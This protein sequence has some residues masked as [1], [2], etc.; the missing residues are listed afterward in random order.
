MTAVRPMRIAMM[1]E[2]DGPGGAEMMVLQL[3][4]ELRERGH[5]IVPVGPAKGCGW[6]ADLFRDAGMKPEVFHMKR[7]I[8]PGCVRGL[9][10]LFREHRIDAVHSHEF[11]MAVYGAASARLMGLPQV[12]T[13]HGGFTACKTRRRRIALRWA[14]KHSDHT[15]MVSRATQ[16]QFATDLG[17]K[18]SRMTVVPNGVPLRK[19]TAERVR[20]EFGVK[21][22]ECVMVAVGTLERHKG[23]HILLDALAGL[24]A[25]G[26]RNPWRLIIAGGR[27]GDQHEPLEEFI[28][29]EGLDDR[30]HIVT[31]R[32]DV[33]DLLALA[34]IFVMPSLWEGLP[35]ALLEAMS[36]SK[37]IIASA[38]SGIPEAIS[39]GKEG[40]LV[41]PGDVNALGSA[42]ASLIAD[43]D[44]RAALGAAA[45][46]RAHREFTVQVM[47]QRYEDLYVDASQRRAGTVGSG[48]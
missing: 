16:R 24:E 42:L 13:M 32:S 28:R 6:L 33:P 11:T 4:E 29:E 3:S 27:G 23:H 26:F 45:H 35:M 20:G 30:V 40:I 14:M 47:A 1:L 41:P 10:Q 18:E 15:V 43:P 12:I 8:D 2:S 39:N 36:S 37:A 22:D 44:R 48:T 38:T 31:N 34:D 5:T 17:L 21:E 7:P 9:M 19:G 25:R 46:T